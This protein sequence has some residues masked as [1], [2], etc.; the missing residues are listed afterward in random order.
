MW[1]DAHPAFRRVI[2]LIGL[3]ALAQPAITEAQQAEAS[4]ACDTR[5]RSMMEN[6][7]EFASFDDR[8]RYWQDQKADCE[9]TAIYYVYLGHLLTQTGR[10]ADAQTAFT[11]GLEKH[12]GSEREL[13]FGLSDVAFRMEKLDEALTIGRQLQQEYPTWAGSHAAVGQAQLALGRYDD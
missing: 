9:K 13:K 8:L 7:S 11:T 12:D 5:Y 6:E 1:H 2:L 4:A 3:T 10:P